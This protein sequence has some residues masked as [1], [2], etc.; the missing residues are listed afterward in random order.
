MHKIQRNSRWDNCEKEVQVFNPFLHRE[1][2]K[3]KYVN[4]KFKVISRKKENIIK[5]KEKFPDDVK[6]KRKRKKGNRMKVVEKYLNV[7][8]V[9]VQLKYDENG[10]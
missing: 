9:N 4:G 5:E 8:K 2:K 7:W 10:K 6:N 1:K 3:R